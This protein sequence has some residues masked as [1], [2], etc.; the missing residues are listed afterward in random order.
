M[1]DAPDWTTTINTNVTV[2][3]VVI[4]TASSS[5]TYGQTTVTTAATA[6]AAPR[7][8]RSGLSIHHLSTAIQNCLRRH[9]QRRHD[10]HGPRARAGD[11]GDLC[12]PRADL[13]HRRHGLGHSLLGGR[14]MAKHLSNA[15]GGGGG[16]GKTWNPAVTS[17]GPTYW[18][19]LAELFGARSASTRPTRNPGVLPART[20]DRSRLPSRRSSPARPTPAPC[21]CQRPLMPRP[22]TATPAFSSPTAGHYAVIAF[23]STA[24]LGTYQGSSGST[25]TRG[26]DQPLGSSTTMLSQLRAGST[27]TGGHRRLVGIFQTVMDG[28]AH[29]VRSAARLAGSPGRRHRHE[30]G[31]NTGDSE[32]RAESATGSPPTSRS[33]PSPHPTAQPPTAAFYRLF[34]AV[35]GLLFDV[36]LAGTPA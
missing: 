9:G 34:D 26:R 24:S 25:T 36:A 33:A 12:H 10:F 27:L 15:P 20:P 5:P 22:R 23:K 7:T 28:Q 3:N 2:D 6:I 18:W 1:S 19:K 11:V 4:T 8:N 17:L 29:L 31:V 14:V 32:R 30:D 16:G 13:W 21:S 35:C